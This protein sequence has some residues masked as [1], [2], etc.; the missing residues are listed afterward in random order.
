M[1]DTPSAARPD[2][3]ACP[4]L[5]RAMDDLVAAGATGVL[6]RVN[7][8]L[9]VRTMAA[10][11]AERGRLDPVPE[12]GLFR[13][14]SV[15]KTFV[16]AVVLLLAAEGE[17]DLDDSVDRYL[18]RFGLDARITIRMLLTHVSG[19]YNYSGENRADGTT[20]PGI[21]PTRGDAYV[22]ELTTSYDPDDLV[23]FALRRPVRFPPGEGFGYSNTNY[24]LAG[25]L[26]EEITG[27]PYGRQVHRRVVE[28][29]GLADT[30]VPG[31]DIAIP[32]PH[33]HGYLGYRQDGQPRV[34]DVTR[35]NPSWYGAA[36]EIISNARDLDVFFTALLD[37]RL[38][39][40]SALTEVTSFT[41]PPPYPGVSPGLFRREFSPG[42]TG[43]GHFGSVPGY[44]CHVYSTFD[45]A[46]RLVMSVTKGA[47]DRFDPTAFSAFQTA[48]DRALVTCFSSLAF[49]S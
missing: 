31:R 33:A 6:V 39:P 48:M 1:Q 3:E 13:I 19:L 26:I 30:T 38:L 36:G 44:L 9:G 25:L 45:G 18:P 17:L 16:A 37:G 7:D 29:L 46:A 2:E 21:F 15:T 27:E 8:R 12:Q 49:P 4:A 40:P 34:A 20:Q 28:P 22:Q 24:V 47:V 11:V 41:P 32:G 10:G 42:R 35:S 5:R 23:G 14:G 43:I